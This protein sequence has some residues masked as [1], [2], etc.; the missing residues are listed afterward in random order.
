MELARPC[1]PRWSGPLSAAGAD[2]ARWLAPIGDGR[3]S[4]GPSS[5]NGLQTH[6]RRRP[7]FN[8]LVHDA[9]A[10]IHG[11]WHRAG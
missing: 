8:Q 2:A 10:A 4:P 1:N 7:A 5:S 3:F 11:R 9:P 6:V